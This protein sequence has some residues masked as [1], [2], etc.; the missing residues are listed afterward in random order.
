MDSWNWIS[1]TQLRE[2]VHRYS[3]LNSVQLLLLLRTLHLKSTA[4]QWF[5]FNPD[6]AGLPESSVNQKSRMLLWLTNPVFDN[7]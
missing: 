3:Q 1:D 7:T 4:L 2:N 6:D 5:S